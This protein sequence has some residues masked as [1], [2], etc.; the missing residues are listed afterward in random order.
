MNRTTPLKR[1]LLTLAAQFTVMTASPVM[2][3]GFDKINDTVVNLNAI[4]VTISVTVVSIAIFW[5]GSKMLFQAAR[6]AD[7]SNIL[8]GGTMIG[9]ASAF[10]AYIVS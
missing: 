9:G 8:I 1:A 2:A 10:A 4:L 5:A 3:A 7:V 6:L